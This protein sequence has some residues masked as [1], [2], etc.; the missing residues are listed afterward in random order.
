ME[1]AVILHIYRGFDEEN[2]Y[3]DILRCT[4]PRKILVGIKHIVKL[5]KS[6]IGCLRTRRRVVV[7]KTFSK[8]VTMI[9]GQKNH[10][11]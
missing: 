8:R 1:E 3:C 11:E 9:G 4:A 10:Q 6:C 7:V 5:I 2:Y